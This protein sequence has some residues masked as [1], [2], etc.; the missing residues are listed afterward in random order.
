MYVDLLIHFVFHFWQL[1]KQEMQKKNI[2]S[3]VVLVLTD[4]TRIHLR[5]ASVRTYTVFTTGFPRFLS[6]RG[7][8][9]LLA[10]NQ[11]LI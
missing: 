5:S 10:L 9:G 7:A 11:V 8:R 2:A 3:I 1:E 6:I 4:K